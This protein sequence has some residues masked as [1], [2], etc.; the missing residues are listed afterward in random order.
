M[1]AIFASHLSASVVSYD[2]PVRPFL[3]ERQVIDEVQDQPDSKA[4]YEYLESCLHYKS[5]M[6]MFE[7][8]RALSGLKN[9]SSRVRATTNISRISL[10][11]FL[12]IYMRVDA[13]ARE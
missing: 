13:T 8:A 3:T 11:Y 6:V 12:R 7:A 1:I 2:M 4:L 9:A 5:E 10:R